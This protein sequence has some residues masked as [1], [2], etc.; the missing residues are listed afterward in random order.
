MELG[1][2]W[3]EA[4]VLT[5][6]LA[7]T[8]LADLLMQATALRRQ[9]HGDRISYSRKVFIPLTQLCRDTCRY[10]TFAD[11]P[12]NLPAAFLTPEQ[13]LDIARRGREAGCHEAL[14]TL[15]DKPELRY[16]EAADFLRQQGYASTV[17][18]LYAMCALVQRETGL[19]PHVNAG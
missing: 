4:A 10:C 15:G 14:F 3:E 18:Y 5:R 9:G 1:Q 19:L 13:V 8:P 2:V 7:E 12:K 17:E 6:R 11:T 16:R